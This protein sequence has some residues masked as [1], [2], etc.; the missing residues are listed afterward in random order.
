MFLPP[1]YFFNDGLDL[2]YLQ[3]C[4]KAIS[5]GETRILCHL[6]PILENFEKKLKAAVWYCACFIVKTFSLE[7]FNTSPYHS[8]L[9]GLS[10]EKRIKQISPLLTVQ[11]GFK[12]NR[13]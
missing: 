6:L 8:V 1:F 10:A 13:V 2:G 9:K 5:A 11:Q 3:L 7:P 12:A 4:K